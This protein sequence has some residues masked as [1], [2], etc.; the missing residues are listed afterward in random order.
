MKDI[1]I[2]SRVILREAKILALCV[3]AAFVLNACCIVHFHTEWKELCTTMP[4]TL[5]VA[6]IFFAVV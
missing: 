3:L 2:T 1:V 6:L 5:A 4:I